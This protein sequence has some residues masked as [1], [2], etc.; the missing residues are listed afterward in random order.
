MYS[1]TSNVDYTVFEI[2]M[3]I[4]VK[5]CVLLS[6]SLFHLHCVLFSHQNKNSK[7]LAIACQIP[8]LLQ[9]FE[10]KTTPNFMACHFSALT[11]YILSY[12]F[13]FTSEEVIP[14]KPRCLK[15]LFFSPFQSATLLKGKHICLYN[16]LTPSFQRGVSIFMFPMFMSLHHFLK[17]LPEEIPWISL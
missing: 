7:E 15:L 5:G 3:C 9:A 13:V 11:N 10:N 2:G 1:A 8:C 14:K 6:A 4:T 16:V 12:I 17:F